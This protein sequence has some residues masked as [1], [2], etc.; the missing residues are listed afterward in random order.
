MDTEIQTQITDEEI[1]ANQVCYV[2]ALLDSFEKYSYYATTD[3]GTDIRL[4]PEVGR[5][6]CVLSE[7][8]IGNV[9]FPDSK[10]T[11]VDAVLSG[12]SKAL[13]VCI[14]AVNFLEEINNGDKRNGSFS[15]IDR[16]YDL[17]RDI[18]K[19]YKNLTRKEVHVLIESVKSEDAV[20]AANALKPYIQQA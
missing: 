9:L 7:A 2:S 10:L 15:S 6:V 14:E 16:L 17:K 12:D 8:L 18:V 11:F 13:M 20:Q 3:K 1:L 19:I 5:A 4:T